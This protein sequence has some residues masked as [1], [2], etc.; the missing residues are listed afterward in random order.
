MSE[1]I[2][3][4]NSKTNHVMVNLVATY[5]ISPAD[6]NSV[7]AI[8]YLCIYEYE[9]EGKKYKYRTHQ[10][11]NFSPIPETIELGFRK[12]P[13]DAYKVNVSSQRNENKSSN[14]IFWMFIFGG[15]SLVIYF[16]YNIVKYVIGSELNI[17]SLL[18]IIVLFIIAINNCLK[19]QK[20]GNNRD[21]MIEDAMLNNRTTTAYLT[22]TTYRSHTLQS[23]SPTMQ[24]HYKERPYK[25]KYTYE[26]EGKKYKKS[27]EFSSS[28]PSS[29]R[30]FFGKN[31]KDIIHFTW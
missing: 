20:K 3:S 1:K 9:Y 31:P 6:A 18:I 7:S 24:Q 4:I 8:D 21:A 30:L 28:P 29:M 23:A 22:K 15:L 27:F 5:D 2:K 17:F 13:S 19:K 10:K 16:I 14:I 12:D 26:Y 11:D 25:G